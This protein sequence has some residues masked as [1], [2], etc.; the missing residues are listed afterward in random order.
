MNP[1]GNL[2]TSRIGLICLTLLAA[3]CPS[4]PGETQTLPPDVGL[5]IHFTGEGTY[6]N[7]VYQ[8]VP[9]KIQAFMKTR[10]GDHFKLPAGAMIQIVYFQNGR[11]ETWRGPVMF[12]VGLEQSQVEGDRSAQPEV[13]FLSPEAYQGLRRLPVVVRRAR[14]SRSG[15]VM[16]R[17]EDAPP[18]RGVILTKEERAEIAM[19]KASY[20]KMRAQARPDDITPE[21]NLLGVLADYEQYGEMERVLWEA[22]KIQ[23]EHPGLKEL[24]E[25]VRAQKAPPSKKSRE[26]AR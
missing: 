6:W 15:G 21:L 24:E 10:K 11:Q 4:I 17:G 2:F 20:Q 13:A 9:E 3:L 12:K 25:W 16:V 8:K 14:L 23:P 26:G 19:A 7:D 22:L 5:V 1:R 18:S